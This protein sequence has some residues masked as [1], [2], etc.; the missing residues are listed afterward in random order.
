MANTPVNFEKA[1]LEIARKLEGEKYAIRGTA[2]LVLQEYDMNVDD[3]DLLGDKKTALSCNDLLKD[4]ITEKVVY[5]ESEKFKS[6]YGK[7]EIYGVL[8]EMMG[9]WQIKRLDKKWS[10]AYDGTERTMLK[11][12]SQEIYVTTVESELEMF[13]QTGRWNAYHKIKKQF[14]E[15]KKEVEQVSLFQ[16]SKS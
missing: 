9:E 10:R 16:N 6:Y 2:S 14:D 8:V 11:I 13:S 7:F 1:I 4:Y 12:E 3:I 15:K 5:R